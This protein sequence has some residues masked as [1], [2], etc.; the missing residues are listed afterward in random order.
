MVLD[1]IILLFLLIIIG[2]IARKSNAVP[3][4]IKIGISKL[5]LNVTLPLYIISAMQFEF[6]PSVLK[7]SGILVLVSFCV[8]A[9]VTAFSVLYTKLLKIEGKKKDVFQYVVIFSNVGYMGYPIMAELA[10]EIGLFYTAIYNL[11]FNLLT[12]TL[13]VYVMTGHRKDI[14]K[15]SYKDRIKAGITPT[16]IAVVLGFMFF[17]FS[18][19]LPLVVKETFDSI[20]R[21]SIPLSMMFI[22]F[23]LSEVH[24]KE[25]FNDWSVILLSFVR[26]L[27]TPITVWLILRA[28]GL[29]GLTLLIPTVISGMPAAASTAIVASKFDNDYRLASK[30][31]FVTTLLSIFTIPILLKIVY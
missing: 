24:I 14:E 10:G 3:I 11:S 19:K 27:L 13:G 4:D 31:I 2:Y 12:W 28:I 29:E 25:I 22:G 8:Y 9:G 18:I 7:D 26:L 16:L 1:K 17:L 6:S 5:V 20:G 15:Q 21:T 30:L 23:I